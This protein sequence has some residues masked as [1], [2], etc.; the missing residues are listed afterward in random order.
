M[1]KEMLV[2]LQNHTHIQCGILMPCC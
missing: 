2:V 1:T